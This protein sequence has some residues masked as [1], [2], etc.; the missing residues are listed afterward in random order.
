[1][2]YSMSADYFYVLKANPYKVHDQTI[3]FGM[4]AGHTTVYHKCIPEKGYLFRALNV[5]ENKRHKITDIGLIA[6]INPKLIATIPKPAVTS[7]VFNKDIGLI[8]I[9]VETFGI[10]EINTNVN[11]VLINDL[12]TANKSCFDLLSEPAFCRSIFQYLKNKASWSKF[13]GMEPYLHQLKQEMIS[14]GVYI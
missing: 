12:K 8:S 13:K 9:V 14:K 1:M 2:R 10:I 6:D 3:L 4:M 7:L 5:F 11:M